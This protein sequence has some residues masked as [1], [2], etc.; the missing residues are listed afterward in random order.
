MSLVD[1]VFGI[2]NEFFGKTGKPIHMGVN[3]FKSRQYN[4]INQRERIRRKKGRCIIHGCKGKCVLSHTIPESAVL[5]FVSYK[6][7]VIY[8]RIN[9][10]TG[11]YEAKAI[12]I[13]KASVFPGFCIEH[14]DLF[15]GY[16]QNG[17]FNHPSI[18]IQNLRVI[19]RCLFDASSLLET[20]KKE[21]LSY[22]EEI[23]DYQRSMISLLN[24]RRNEKITLV[25]VKDEIT[26]HMQSNIDFLEGLVAEITNKDL[27]PFIKTMNDDCDLVSVIAVNLDFELP[28][29]L[30]GKSGFRSSNEKYTV[31]LSIFSKPS[32][33]VLC[34][35]LPKSYELNFMVI[36]EKFK[37][38]FDFLKFIES[39]MIYGTDFWYINPLE[40]DS[41]SSEKKERI[42]ALMKDTDHFPDE[43]L[44]FSIFETVRGTLEK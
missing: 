6:N 7:N 15:S 21:F 10:E 28:I 36:L 37:S 42:L 34:F 43:E 26:E 33:T 1:K 35:S 14:E 2:D 11:K 13:G 27:I 31:H 5:K 24:D 20:F 19:Y 44:G 8:P 4:F 41:Y 9:T 23:N 40:W 3:Y 17:N 30:A 22:K 32:E 39:W 18:A 25:D 16:E 38:D 12:H 29:C